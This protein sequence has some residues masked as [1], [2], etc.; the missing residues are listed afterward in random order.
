MKFKRSVAAVLA[1]LNLLLMTTPLFSNQGKK[2]PEDQLQALLETL[3]LNFSRIKTLKAMMKQEKIIPVFSEKVISTGFCIFKAPDKLRLDFTEPFQSSLMVNG[4]KVLKY[5]FFNGLWHELVMGNRDILLMITGNIA[6]W[7]KGRF[8][9][10][11]LYDISAWKNETLTI[12][13]VPKADEFKKFISSFELGVNSR[14]DGLD[15]IIIHENKDSTTRIE[16]YNAG[17]NAD[18]DDTVFQ[19]GENGPSLVLPW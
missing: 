16:F 8:K 18:I 1:I 11:K 14:L 12:R 3:E 6:S 15:Y 17:Q 9:D 7:L 5:E 4:D 10:P 19:G 13:L 2:I